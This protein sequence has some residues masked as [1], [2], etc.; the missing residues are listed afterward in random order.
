MPGPN[1]RYAALDPHRTEY[2]DQPLYDTVGYLA[3][4]AVQYNFFAIPLGQPAV[5]R[6][7]LGGVT[8]AAPLVNK[9][10]RDTN[11]RIAGI[12]PGEEMWQF[13][14][15][16]LVFRRAVGPAAATPEVITD[17]ADEKLIMSNGWFLVRIGLKDILTIPSDLVPVLNPVINTT[18]AGQSLRA[19]GMVVP[20]YSFGTP[21]T[22]MGGQTINISLNFPGQIAI[23]T[24]LDILLTLYAKMSRPT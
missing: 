14:G 3:A 2:F 6:T 15:F 22:V 7:L 11:M 19:N 16:N 24:P 5:L 17:L 10:Y 21:I 1:T 12:I 20:M 23:V 13:N 4:G 8:A 18:W 9:S